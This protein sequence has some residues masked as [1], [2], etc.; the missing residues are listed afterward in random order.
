MAIN[1][2]LPRL[3]ILLHADIKGGADCACA[4]SEQDNQYLVAIV[5]VQNIKILASRCS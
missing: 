4:Q 3:K 2:M 1:H 5:I